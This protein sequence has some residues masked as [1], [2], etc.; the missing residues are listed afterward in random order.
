L[1]KHFELKQQQLEI[2]RA[3]VNRQTAA[4]PAPNAYQ[5][6]EVKKEQQLEQKVKAWIDSNSD[7]EELYN[8]LIAMYYNSSDLTK[9]AERLNEFNPEIYEQ[10]RQAVR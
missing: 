10:C 2:E 3:R 6:P 9:F 8:N 7:N 4:A 5:A 1:D